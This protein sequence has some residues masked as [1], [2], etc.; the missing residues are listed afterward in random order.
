MVEGPE[1][2][3]WGAD[4]TTSYAAGDL[5]DYSQVVNLDL[6]YESIHIGAG[7]TPFSLNR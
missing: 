6:W 3:G 2:R 4:F 7:Q 5:A 1:S